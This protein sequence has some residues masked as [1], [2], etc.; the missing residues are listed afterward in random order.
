MGGGQ[1]YPRVKIR[2]RRMKFVGLLKWQRKHIEWQAG[3]LAVLEKKKKEFQHVFS[4]Q[5]MFL[6]AQGN[7]LLM[8]A[9]DLVQ[10]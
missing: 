4:K 6:L 10:E 8:V 5:L 2:N 9:N 1:R 3:L 7:F